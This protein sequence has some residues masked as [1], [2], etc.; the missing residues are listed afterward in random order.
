MGSYRIDEIE[1]EDGGEH[2]SQEE[3]LTGEVIKGLKPSKGIERNAEVE[4]NE[5]IQFSDGVTQKAVGKKHEQGG[6]D[7]SIPDGTKVVSDHLKIGASFAKKLEKEFGIKVKAD[8]TYAKAID[9]YTSKIGLKK[10][11]EEQEDLFKTLKKE[12]DTPKDEGSMRL[13]MEYLSG[14]ISQVESKKKG[15]EEQ[16]AQFFNVVFNTQE[17]SKGAEGDPDQDTFK[18]GGV[19]E[20]NFEQV[21]KK[22]GLTK[23]QGK[24]M[25]RDGGYVVPQYQDGDEHGDGPGDPEFKFT[26]R[27]NPYQT[28]DR[29][30]QSAKPAVG[31]GNVKSSQDALQ[32]L[33]N[34]FPDL[35]TETFGGKYID[36]DKAGQ[37]TF[38]GGIDLGRQQQIVL[39]LQEKMNKRMAASASAIFN[40][41]S[42]PQ[43]VRDKA[44]TGWIMNSLQE[45]SLRTNQKIFE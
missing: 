1:F 33:Y 10:L 29:V 8:D 15:L 4:K 13:N 38:K 41:E 22:Y 26:Y 32:Q 18:M 25:L 27:S 5:Y 19:S 43:E 31:Y 42:L 2:A 20:K 14:K 12:M 44:K 16:R 17:K 40:D 11:N 24:Q 9:K 34:N 6:V 36:V 28:E 21:C 23:E 30:K 37:V 3:L 45:R 7:L 35:V 39:D